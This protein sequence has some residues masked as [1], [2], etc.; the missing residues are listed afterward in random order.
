MMKTIKQKVLLIAVGGIFLLSLLLIF[1]AIGKLFLIHE[2]TQEAKKE[3]IFLEKTQFQPILKHPAKF[4][5]NGQFIQANEKQM[6]YHERPKK[7]QVLGTITFPTLHKSYPIVEGTDDASL[8]SGVGHYVGSVL[9]G[10]TDNSVLAGHRDTVFT[11]LGKLKTGDVIIIK[12]YAGTFTYI[13][14]NHRIV[15]GDDRT[16]IVPSDH[17]MLTLVTCYPFNYIGH[18]PQRY[19]ITAD[20][21]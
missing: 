6:L 16:V 14:N 12:T 20:L 18:A 13:I 10:E 2:A 15:N 7:G 17:A 11:G 19:I 4:T 5:M 21:K 8:K 1:L 3:S 9:P